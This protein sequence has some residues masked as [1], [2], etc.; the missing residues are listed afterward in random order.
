MSDQ[1]PL[2]RPARRHPPERRVDARFRRPVEVDDFGTEPRMGTVGQLRRKGF[3]P[4][5]QEPEFRQRADPRLLEQHFEHRGH[6]LH[7]GDASLA[8]R[9]GQGRG[10][11]A[12]L[13]GVQHEHGIRHQGQVELPD[14]S[15]EADG[16]P[17]EDPVVGRDGELPAHPQHVIDDR[18]VRHRDAARS[19]RRSRREDDV[20]RVVRS[21]VAGWRIARQVFERG[22]RSPIVRQHEVDPP[23][24]RSSPSGAP[25]DSPAR[26][27]ARAAGGPCGWPAGRAAKP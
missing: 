19:P 7:D 17:L 6:H 13:G 5:E 16:G 23:A 4:A 26:S 12:R 27:L 20:R 1:H 9:R 8:E 3:P 18:P 15:V 22:V 11:R 24:R 25:R 2:R 21:R 14:R 10:V